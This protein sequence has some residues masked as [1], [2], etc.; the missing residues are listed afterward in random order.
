MSGG[1]TA[2]DGGRRTSPWPVFVALG[3][4]VAELGVFFGVVPLAV[5]G[6]VV[7]G[8]SCSGLLTEVRSR[9][10]P[11][12]S[13]IPVGVLF[14]IIG[15]G[16]WSAGVSDFTASGVLAAP[17][18]DGVALRGAAVLTGGV[19]LVAAGAGAH[20]WSTFAGAR[21]GLSE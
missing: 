7:F 5:G 19:V 21:H 1:P 11:S 3:F 18:V 8:G 20:V 2:G 15:I 10:S 6:I 12:R 13:L 14:V 4:A 16:L 17:R 9:S